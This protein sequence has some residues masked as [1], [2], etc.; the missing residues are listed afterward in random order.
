MDM[1]YLFKLI[2]IDFS[3]KKA[4][5]DGSKSSVST[6]TRSMTK[7]VDYSAIRANAAGRL[8]C[9]R[10]KTRSYVNRHLLVRHLQYECGIE[11]RFSCT[12]C[13]KKFSQKTV[14]ER[15]IRTLHG[16]RLYPCILCAKIFKLQKNLEL[17]FKTAHP[18]ARIFSCKE[19]PKI[20]KQKILLETHVRHVHHDE[21]N[22]SCI[23]CPKKFKQKMHLQRHYKNI[24]RKK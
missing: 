1:M 17:H 2:I 11:R 16:N 14:L 8:D 20:F 22:F 19:C 3:D 4:G 18:S 23:A 15:H 21:R 5:P 10:C 12:E 13:P 6:V 24:H 7:Q 9:P